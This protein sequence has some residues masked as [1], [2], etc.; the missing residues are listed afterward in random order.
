MRALT[1]KQTE[2]VPSAYPAAPDGLSGAAAALS[3]DMLWQ[4][5]E[6]YVAHRWTAR[7]VEWL[8]E[9]PGDWTAP[10]APASIATVEV[11]SAVGAWESVTLDA[12]PFGGYFLPAYGPYRFTATGAGLQGLVARVRGRRRGDLR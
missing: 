7:S 5:I 2:G 8:V 3:A 6:A 1:I 12:S 11:W 10:L 4:R 9:G